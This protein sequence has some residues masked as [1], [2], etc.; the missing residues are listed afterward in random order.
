MTLVLRATAEAML[1]RRSCNSL[2]AGI[3]DVACDELALGVHVDAS[4]ID[5][6]GEKGNLRATSIKE[7]TSDCKFTLFRVRY[8]DD[9]NWWTQSPFT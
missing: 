2:C 1:V 9:P 7:G 4:V 3:E 8:K 6:L 5:S